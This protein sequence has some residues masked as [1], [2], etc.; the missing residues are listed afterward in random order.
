MFGG[1]NQEI[2]QDILFDTDS[3]IVFITGT[4]W[5]DDFP[6]TTNGIKSFNNEFS[7]GFLIGINLSKANDG[8][9]I[10]SS[11]LGGSDDDNIYS[12]LQME[13]EIFLTGETY[14]ENLA[15]NQALDSRI[16]S[17]EAFVQ[18]IPITEEGIW[19][20]P[21]PLKTTTAPRRLMSSAISP[22]TLFLLLLTLFH[23]RKQGYLRCK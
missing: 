8:S 22:G 17:G 4:T 16:E 14:S 10:Y 9:L 15:N 23:Y 6:I 21:T 20:A 7:D 5:S 12:F 18:K 1:T 3:N 13:S 11:Y 19:L 2:A